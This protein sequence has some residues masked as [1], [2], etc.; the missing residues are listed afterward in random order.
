MN[1][2]TLVAKKSLPEEGKTSKDYVAKGNII[3]EL[4]EGHC[5]KNRRE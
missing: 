2:S 1:K 5:G 4:K 3:R